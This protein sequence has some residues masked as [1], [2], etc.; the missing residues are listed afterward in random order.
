MNS[1]GGFYIDADVE[2]FKPIDEL[3]EGRELIL[4]KTV[5]YNNAIIGSAPGHLL[6][7]VVFAN[8]QKYSRRPP[9]RLLRFYESYAAVSAGPRL[10]TRLVEESGFDHAPA[11]LMC[12][13][14]FFEPDAPR[15]ENGRLVR[16]A[17]LSE[18]YARHFMDVNWLSPLHRSVSQLVARVSRAFLANT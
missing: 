2:N 17:D 11:T 1:Q 6:W 18:S 3:A 14:S 9:F 8:L 13:G 4:S 15:L 7:Q 10:F 5:I 12:P 16:S